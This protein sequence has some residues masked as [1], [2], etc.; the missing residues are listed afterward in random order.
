[1]SLLNDQ[2]TAHIIKDLNRPGMVADEIQEELTDHV[3]STVEGEMKNGS[4]FLNA[5]HRVLRSFGHNN[6]LR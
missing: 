2:H 3:C 6:G 1:M 4:R 5:Y